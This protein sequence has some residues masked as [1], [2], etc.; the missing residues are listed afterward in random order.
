MN[1]FITGASGFIGRHLIKRLLLRQFNI[2]AC[3]HRHELPYDVKIF[4]CDFARFTDTEQWLPY[5]KNMDVVINCVGI[6]AESSK[7]D[8]ENIHVKAPKALF[9]ACEVAGVKRVIHISALGVAQDMATAAY[10][11][12]KK[13]ADEALMNTKLDW[14]ILKPSLVYGN[15]GKSFE[16]FKKLSQLPVVPLIDGGQQLIQPIQ[17][18][19]LLDVIEKC[20]SAA[21]SHQILNVVGQQAITYQQWMKHINPKRRQWRFFNIPMWLAK[22][23]A[24]LLKPLKLQFIT[25]DNLSMLAQHNIADPAPLHVFLEK[26]S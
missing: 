19:I 20:L 9:M 22:F 12:S 10:Q 13:A 2:T 17:V 16:W 15:G 3:I 18:G 1:I 11:K 26:T 21:S 7:N 6:I 4:R 5:L 14:F 8:F 25:T 24:C 23:T